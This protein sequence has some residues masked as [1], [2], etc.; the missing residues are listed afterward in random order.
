MAPLVNI[1]DIFRTVGQPTVTYVQRN[2]GLFEG[3]LNRALDERGQLCLVTGPSKT[4]KTTL[5]REVLSKREEIPLVIACD[6][7]TS[8]EL[9]WRQAL[10]AVDFERAVSQASKNTTNKSL[11]VE[12]SGQLGWKWLAG[13][14]AKFKGAFGKQA[15]EE[16]VKEKIIA[17][18]GPDLLIPVLQN[19]NYV[20]II[21]DFHYLMDEEK[22]LLFQQWKRF[23]DNEVTVIVLGT[24]HR[25]IDIASSNKDLVGRITQIDVG[26]WS[27]PDLKRICVQG[28]GHLKIF[29]PDSLAT[30][31]SLEA[32]GLP[33]I[34]QRVCLEL[35]SSQGI[36][37]I[38]QVSAATPTFDHHS[39]RLSLH[40]VARQ[41]YSQL[42]N[43]YNILIKGPREKS[44]KYKT[45]ELVLACF[46]LDPI[47]FRLSK[48]NI[49]ERIRKL[50]IET[51]EIPPPP[52]V[53][54]TLGALRKY[55]ERRGIELLEWR[56]KEDILYILEPVFLF[57]VRWRKL[58]GVQSQNLDIFEKLLAS[59][60]ANW[61][62][63][64]R[65]R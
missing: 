37:A 44:R 18:A 60:T 64:L 17:A 46:T 7:K 65:T 8:T 33:I 25:A 24:T 15:T 10:E 19:S 36:A 22:T 58:L 13:V 12:G 45:Y 39:L 47:S 59:I 43:Y 20:L 30:I 49:H 28:F 2:S 52:S 9:V 11:E 63:Y 55:Q 23:I 56:P 54:S 50:K 61:N 40:N 3:L 21:E 4:G 31:L 34:V 27:A 29:F 14:S 32:A 26:N 41:R 51:S 6:K 1:S 35:L 48:A 5:Y 62:A 57:Y 53:N 16:E 38:A 42:E